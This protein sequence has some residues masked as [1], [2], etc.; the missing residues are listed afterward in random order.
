[1]MNMMTFH[2]VPLYFRLGLW[3][4]KSPSPPLKCMHPDFTKLNAA[5]FREAKWYCFHFHHLHLLF[6]I[7]VSV[8]LLYHFGI[9]LN[10]FVNVSHAL[11]AIQPYPPKE[12]HHVTQKPHVNRAYWLGDRDLLLQLLMELSVLSS[13]QLPIRWGLFNCL[14]DKAAISMQS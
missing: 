3:R 6:L 12:L 7:M 1:M 11:N 2:S 8:F 4:V 14:R 9:V 10:L 13:H 5:C